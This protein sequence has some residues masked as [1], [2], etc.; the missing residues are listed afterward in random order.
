MSHI[1]V[2]VSQHEALLADVECPPYADYFDTRHYSNGAQHRVPRA[3]CLFEKGAAMPLRRH[4][5]ATRDDYDIEDN[6]SDSD[7]EEKAN[8]GVSGRTWRKRLVEVS[9]SRSFSLSVVAVASLIESLTVETLTVAQPSQRFVWVAGM[10]DN[11]LVLRMMLLLFNYDF[12]LDYT[13]HQN[14]AVEVCTHV[15][16]HTRARLDIDIAGASVCAGGH[17]AHRLRAHRLRARAG[18]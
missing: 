14:G 10:P 8:A 9:A 16:R 17:N 6:D 3:V 1:R 4:F 5:E 11:A 15:M 7:S 18:T 13:F 12:M 2:F